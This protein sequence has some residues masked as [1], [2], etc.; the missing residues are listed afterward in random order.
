MSEERRLQWGPGVS[1]RIKGRRKEGQKE[2]EATKSLPRVQDGSKG[3]D[4]REGG[5]AG[6]ENSDVRWIDDVMWGTRKEGNKR[7]GTHWVK[8]RNEGME[9]EWSKGMGVKDGR[10]ERNG[11]PVAASRGRPVCPSV[12]RPGLTTFLSALQI[13]FTTPKEQATDQLSRPPRGETLCR[14]QLGWSGL[15]GLVG[16]KSESSNRIDTNYESQKESEY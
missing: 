6:L 11:L 8:K 5:M 10:T 14:W 3:Y 2:T 9:K 16:R 1:V 15:A 4:D 12:G 7:K 13:W